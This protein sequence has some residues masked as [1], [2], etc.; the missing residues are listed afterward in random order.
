MRRWTGLQG[1]FLKGRHSPLSCG[2][3]WFANQSRPYCH[4]PAFLH[5]VVFLRARLVVIKSYQCLND[6]AL[7]AIP[8]VVFCSKYWFPTFSFGF[9]GRGN[10]E[11]VV[12]DLRS[13][14]EIFRREYQLRT[15]DLK[16][17][18]RASSDWLDP[19]VNCCQVLP[20]NSD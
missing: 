5:E 2:C 8:W 19:K 10:L 3:R 18:V 17:Q 6:G 14:N 12:S 9:A 7:L 13:L 15:L 1:L 20:P 4:S 16:A 11:E